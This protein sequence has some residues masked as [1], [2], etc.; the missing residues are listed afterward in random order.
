MDVTG[1]KTDIT[2]AAAK[3]KINF[4]SFHPMFAPV[5]ADWQGRNVIVTEYP[6][7]KKWRAWADDFLAMTKA[8]VSELSPKEHDEQMALIQALPHALALVAASALRSKKVDQKKLLTRATP[9]YKGLFSLMT[10]VLSKNPELYAEIQMDN[11]RAVIP[12]L[13]Q[14]IKEMQ[15]FKKIVAAKDSKK[16]VAE[17]LK[18]KEYFGDDLLK[19]GDAL[20]ETMHFKK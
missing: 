3:I 20:F 12:V 5:G 11:A 19:E 4:F 10:R 2:S 13:D 15:S 17:F 18:N 1:L 14:L 9:V 7:S 6:V 16:F 8:H